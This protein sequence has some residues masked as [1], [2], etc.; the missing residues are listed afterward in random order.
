MK[1]IIIIIISI[2]LA[3]C[4]KVQNDRDFEVTGTSAGES[5]KIIAVDGCEYI[6]WNSGYGCGICHH[7][8]C[9][10]CKQRKENNNE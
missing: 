2:L 1:T 4:A 7:E 3:S 5:V 8:N 6:T 9:K 10:Y